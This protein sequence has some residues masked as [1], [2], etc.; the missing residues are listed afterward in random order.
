VTFN[1]TRREALPFVRRVLAND[2]TCDPDDFLA[3]GVTINEFEPRAGG[4]G[5]RPPARSFLAVTFGNGT[6]IT[7]HAD[8]IEPVRA[9][10]TTLER[11]EFF[12]PAGMGP[13]YN[14]FDANGMILRS[15]SLK[16]VLTADHFTPS[17]GYEEQTRLLEADEVRPL[18]NL[19][20]FPHS[21][22]DDHAD[23]ERPLLAGMAYRGDRLI[24]AAVACE[25]AEG[26]W[27]IGV[28]VLPEGRGSG[29]GLAIVSRVSA[30]ILERGGLPYYS[31]AAAN[32][33]SRSIA[34]RIGF[35]PAFTESYAVDKPSG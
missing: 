28:D 3:D 1:Q 25:E 9:L 20:G 22:E 23:V 21:L 24:A 33:A 34:H 30:A 4:R 2:Y 5:Y 14:L 6:V 15:P 8:F 17:E 29:L 16:H 19:P 31:A 10:A 35:W 7:S 11:D 18:T 26:F 32:I 12:Q 27:Q 13:L